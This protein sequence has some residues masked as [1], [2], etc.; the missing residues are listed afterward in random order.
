MP[1][2]LEKARGAKLAPSTGEWGAD[3]VI[4]YHLGEITAE[5]DYIVPKSIGDEMRVLAKSLMG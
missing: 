1:I 4:L 3:Q 5:K 2:D